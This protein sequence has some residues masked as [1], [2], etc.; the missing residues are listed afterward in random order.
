LI[1]SVYLPSYQSIVGRNSSVGIATQY[2]LVG[3]EIEYGWG[4]DFPHLSIPTQ[5]A[6]CT[7]GIGSL[8]EVKRPESDVDHSHISSAEFKERV[9]LYLYPLSGILCLLQGKIY[10][11]MPVHYNVHIKVPSL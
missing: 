5:R 9:E 11:Y 2:M 1:N 4:R 10:S 7:L 6:S 8:P 3:P